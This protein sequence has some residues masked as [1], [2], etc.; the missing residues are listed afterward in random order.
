MGHVQCVLPVHAADADG[1]DDQS[2]NER[3]KHNDH[4][5]CTCNTSHQQREG[6][7][8]AG[9][10]YMYTACNDLVGRRVGGQDD[11][12]VAPGSVTATDRRNIYRCIL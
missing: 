4:S 9:A 8:L 1:R 6:S 5:R 11:D 10:N 12:G 7:D 3:D 2:D